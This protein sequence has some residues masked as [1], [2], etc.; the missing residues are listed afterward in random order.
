M[1]QKKLG[2]DQDGVFGEDTKRALIKWQ[3]ANGLDADGV[4]GPNTLAVMFRN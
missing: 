2:L 1:L 4:A 3:S